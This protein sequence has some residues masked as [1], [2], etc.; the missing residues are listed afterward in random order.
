M[1]NECGVVG[2]EE[3]PYQLLHGLRVGLKSPEFEKAAVKVVADV[4][5]V[6]VVKV[7]SGLLE[8]CAEEDGEESRC[9]DASLFH[10]IGDCKRRKRSVLSLT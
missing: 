9:Q 4:D 3:V 5:E 6:F 7:L 1:C 8:H 10:T 2:E